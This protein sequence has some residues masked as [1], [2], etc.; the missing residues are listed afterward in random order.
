MNNHPTEQ[1]MSQKS[2]AEEMKYGERQILEGEL[3]TFPNPR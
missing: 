1:S 2:S 3:I